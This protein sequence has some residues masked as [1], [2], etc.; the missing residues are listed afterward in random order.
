MK[1]TIHLDNATV[2]Y[3]GHTYRIVPG[4]YEVERTHNTGVFGLEYTHCWA[5]ADAVS[6]G[7]VVCL[8]CFEAVF[9]GG[10]DANLGIDH[11]VG[12]IDLEED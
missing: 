9:V 7:G 5:E 8:A 12:I 2:E 11:F 4:D 1:P 6:D 3:D 10:D